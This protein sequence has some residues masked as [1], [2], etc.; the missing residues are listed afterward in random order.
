[1]LYTHTT[2][3]FPHARHASTA[4][5][6]WTTGQH[7]IFLP[8][9]RRWALSLGELQVD[10]ISHQES[11]RDSPEPWSVN[12]A[13]VS[14]LKDRNFTEHFIEQTALA[15]ATSPCLSVNRNISTSLKA[16]AVICGLPCHLLSS[17]WT[18]S[19]SD[20]LKILDDNREWPTMVIRIAIAWLLWVHHSTPIGCI[21]WP[22]SACF[23]VVTESSPYFDWAV[24]QHIPCYRLAFSFNGIVKVC[25]HTDLPPTFGYFLHLHFWL[26]LYFLVKLKT[27]ESQT[28]IQLYF[29]T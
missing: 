14:P 12:P 5:E 18:F 4:T 3:H 8:A 28:K 10:D 27:L 19:T 13:T 9:K 20:V 21:H 6:E 15:P 17:M 16:A 2:V 26:S 25:S 22:S 24:R 1:M 29:L 11:G 23:Y 7:R